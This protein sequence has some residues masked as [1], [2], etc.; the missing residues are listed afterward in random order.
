MKPTDEHLQKVRALWR[1]DGDLGFVRKVENWIYH[2]PT[3]RLFLRLTEPSHRGEAQLKA[4]LDWMTHLEKKGI[5]LASPRLSANGNYVEP[6]GF[7]GK[8]FY[9]SA[10]Q[11]ANGERLAEPEGFTRPVLEKWGR[12]LGEMHAA[13]SSY[14]PSS[15][16]QKRPQWNEEQN[17]LHI[18]K[19]IPKS[20]GKLFE[21]FQDLQA[22]MDP[23][24]QGPAEYGLVHADLHHGNFHVDPL[25]EFTVFDF[26][27]C[28]YHWYG[29][30]IAV[31]IFHIEYTLWRKGAS[32][33]W[34]SLSDAF[35]RG[36]L[37][38]HALSERWIQS[39]PRFL[40][41]RTFV[42]YCWNLAN[43]KNDD[44]DRNSKDWME[45]AIVYCRNV[46]ENPNSNNRFT[47]PP[48]SAK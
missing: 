2:H 47:I 39:V 35:W 25:G 41:Y 7:E 12:L 17:Y 34:E 37:S 4:E 48:A 24:S 20:D 45:K 29:Y 43:L 14:R 11:Q 6:V 1:L 5:R 27:D 21:R 9:T 3:S 28:H 44:L 16:I 26:D 33:S 36:Y 8:V 30:D 15:A 32:Q 46:L 22:W 10:F 40:E 31:P 38:A 23:L 13:T 19:S 42:L 18:R